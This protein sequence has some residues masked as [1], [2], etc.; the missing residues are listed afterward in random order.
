MK[1][2]VRLVRPFPTWT[3]LGP[4][5]VAPPPELAVPL[6]QLGV[7]EAERRGLPRELGPLLREAR[8][9]HVV[10]RHAQ[11]VTHHDRTL[12]RQL[13]VRQGASH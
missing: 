10:Q 9:V 5:V 6:E 11:L 7:P 13:H 1:S 2:V 4:A 8:V 12:D 3:Y